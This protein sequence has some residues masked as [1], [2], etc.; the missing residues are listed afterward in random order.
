VTFRDARPADLE[1]IVAVYNAAVP[2]GEA[3]AD[4]EPVAP[5]SRRRWLTERDFERRPVW[6]CEVEGAVAAWLSFE[7]FYGRPAYD[8]AAEI[9][10]YVAPERRG[11]GLGR[12]LLDR[13]VERAHLLGLTTMLAFVFAHNATSVGLFRRR[14]FEEW[15]RLPRV[16][17]MPD[18]E[19]DVLILGRRASVPDLS[20]SK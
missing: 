14:G 15:G 2:D 1:R 11:S 20:S 3:T 7:D 19:R 17:R 12:G 9:A 8:A 4:T 13:A 18:G 10:V 6:V 16:A 5:E